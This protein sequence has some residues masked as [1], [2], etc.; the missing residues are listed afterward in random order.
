MKHLD[1]LLPYTILPAKLYQA[2]HTHI[3]APALASLL[4]YGK[5]KEAFHCDLSTTLPEEF[6]LTQQFQLAHTQNNHHYSVQLASALMQKF[7]P[8]ETDGYWF[9]V[10]PCHFNVGMNQI[11]LTPFQQLLLSDT[12]SQALFNTA[13]QVVQQYDMQLRYGNPYL[14]FLKADPWDTLQTTS[15]FAI[16]G[17]GID[18]GLPQGEHARAWRKIHN[19]I[20]MHWYADPINAQREQVQ[21]L[22]VNGLWLWG[23]SD[24]S[25][26]TSPSPYQSIFSP[27]VSAFNAFQ[28]A[29]HVQPITTFPTAFE[30]NT[31]LII[32]QLMEAYL[33]EDWGRWLHQLNELDQQWF[34][35]CLSAL[36]QHQL[37]HLRFILTDLHQFTVYDGAVKPLF[38]LGKA[39]SLKALQS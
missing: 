22:A 16:Q 32:D 36:K 2:M 13:Q 23:G 27:T 20:Q 3:A 25:H 38:A 9:I 31:L 14:W 6:W 4:G 1:I 21:Q 11:T 24:L 37:S 17:N 8:D 39:P 35:P 29:L 5:R 10:Q 12:E 28:Q 19:D 15:P 30:D 33:E 26:K 18:T 7:H 34:Q